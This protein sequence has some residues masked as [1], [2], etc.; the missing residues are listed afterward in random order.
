MEYAAPGTDQKGPEIEAAVTLE[1][2]EYGQIEFDSKSP[3]DGGTRSQHAVLDWIIWEGTSRDSFSR[4][5]EQEFAKQ[6]K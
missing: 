5:V 6:R 3:R 1:G 2:Q 4:H